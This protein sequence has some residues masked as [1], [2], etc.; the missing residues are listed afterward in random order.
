M[1]GCCNQELLYSFPRDLIFTP[2]I[3]SAS[4][5]S[6]PLVTQIRRDI[7]SCQKSTVDRASCPD[8]SSWWGPG[9]A[10]SA[11]ATT[12]LHKL[13]EGRC[14]PYFLDAGPVN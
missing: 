14:Y 9:L 11:P 5:V 1:K 3:A 12:Q 7:S 13:A 10:G 6:P 2:C 8:C 4:R